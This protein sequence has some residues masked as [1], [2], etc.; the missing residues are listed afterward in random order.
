[1]STHAADHHE[2]TLVQLSF[3]FYLL[4]AKPEHL[5]GDR[6]YDSDGLDDDLKQDG[7]NM[8]AQH[9]SI[10]K[11]KTAV[12]SATFNAAG[13]SSASLPGCN[14]RGACSSAG[15]LRGQL[16]GFCPTC[17]HHDAAKAILR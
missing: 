5:I 15:R 9:W 7:A 14:G 3:D 12:P 17:I 1:V 6:A 13:S 16:P 8:I 11:L 10:R 2:V 4:E